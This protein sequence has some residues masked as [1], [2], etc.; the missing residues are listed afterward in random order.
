LN[1]PE[2]NPNPD[3]HISQTP[4]QLNP[5]LRTELIIAKNRDGGTGWFT[6]S[7]NGIRKFLSKFIH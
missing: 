6:L 5:N 7:E 4:S 3:S 2:V 1:G